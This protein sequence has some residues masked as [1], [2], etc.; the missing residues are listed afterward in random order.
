MK[1][2]GAGADT[3]CAVNYQPGDGEEISTVEDTVDAQCKVWP[4]D[5]IRAPK[6]PDT[7]GTQQQQAMNIS[8][9]EGWGARLVGMKCGGSR[10]LVFPPTLSEGL[11]FVQKG[12][13][14][15]DVQVTGIQ[16][17][18]AGAKE[19]SAENETSAHVVKVSPT[20][21]VSPP[22]SESGGGGK[23]QT[24]KERMARIG[25]RPL[26]FSG[27]VAATPSSEDEGPESPPLPAPQ[28]H[29]AP[30]C[31][32]HN[33]ASTESSGLPQPQPKPRNRPAIVKSR[34]NKGLPSPSPITPTTLKPAPVPSPRPPP[35]H[36]ASGNAGMYSSNTSKSD[37]KFAQESAI[38][39]RKVASVPLPGRSVSQNAIPYGGH[40]E[41]AAQMLL[42]ALADRDAAQNELHTVSQQ[43]QSLTQ[44]VSA[45][46][47]AMD[48]LGLLIKSQNPPPILQATKHGSAPSIDPRAVA[49]TLERV[50]GDCGSAQKGVEDTGKRVDGLNE[51]VAR[52]LE[53]NSQALAKLSLV[54]KE[55]QEAEAD[56]AHRKRSADAN[57]QKH[58]QLA[59]DAAGFEKRKAE[60]M[61]KINGA[62]KRSQESK[63]HLEK[64]QTA[65]E[66]RKKKNKDTFLNTASNDNDVDQQKRLA[67]ARSKGLAKAL[68]EETRPDPT[69]LKNAVDQIYSILVDTIDSNGTYSGSQ[70]LEATVQALRGGTAAALR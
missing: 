52:L 4:I 51:E 46:E 2:A 59:H 30:P 49:V 66:T 28:F 8:C 60:L 9:K 29:P 37:Q 1:C 26:L 48:R 65:A 34:P 12:F 55:A 14:L 47:G 5:D 24:L 70:V 20:I 22:Q 44:L 32:D 3:V 42:Q 68:N 17:P 33:P 40:D 53:A 13:L 58:Q 15:V 39:A 19:K 38:G 64:L 16:R 21:P 35:A 57:R 11:P 36:L 7:S 50:I 27:A 63:L 45:L 31:L 6:P 61:Q 23:R 56:T 43:V 41:S 18:E 10:M 54:T 69:R 67:D 62:E 25:A